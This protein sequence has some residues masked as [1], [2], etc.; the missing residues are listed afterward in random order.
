MYRIIVQ[1]F[2]SIKG[3]GIRKSGEYTNKVNDIEA[4]YNNDNKYYYLSSINVTHNRTIAT[5]RNRLDETLFK[6]IIIENV[7]NIT[8]KYR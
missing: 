2:T 7:D 8:P 4:I 5:I 1:S 3:Y 6:V